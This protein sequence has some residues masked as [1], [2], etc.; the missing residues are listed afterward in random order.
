[1][2]KD[3]AIDRNS[4]GGTMGS[5]KFL[6]LTAVLLLSAM[7]CFGGEKSAS[8]VGLVPPIKPAT[9]AA[10][11]AKSQALSSQPNASTGPVTPFSS[12]GAGALVAATSGACFGST[13]TASNG[14]SC[15]CLQFE[16]A[17]PTTGLGNAA[18]DFLITDNTV[19]CLDTGRVGLCCPFDGEAFLANSSSEAGSLVTGTF[20]VNFDLAGTLGRVFTWNATY[21]MLPDTGKFSQAAGTG[22]FSVECEPDLSARPAIQNFVGNVQTKSSL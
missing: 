20:C 15:E 5:R 13:C 17:G 19:D 8:V 16:G 4:Q 11:K 9:M 6:S 22:N 14:T 7:P 2:L 1:M 10:F 12:R 3:L 21:A 18:F